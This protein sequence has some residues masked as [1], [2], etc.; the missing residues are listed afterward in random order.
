MRSPGSASHDRLPLRAL[1]ALAT[2]AFITVLT[3][4]LPAGVLPGMSRDIGVSESAMGQS[5]TVYAIGSALAAVPLSAATAGWSRKRL[6]LSTV[7]GFAVANSVTAFATDYWLSMGARFVAGL[8]AGLVW[9]MLAGYARRVAPARQHGKAVAIVMAGVPLALS[10]GVPAGTFLGDAVGWRVTFWSMTGIAVVLMG[11]MLVLVPDFPG[12]VGRRGRVLGALAVPGVTAVL[13]A[14]A[15]YVLAQA[16]LYTYI[17]TYLDRAG[18]ADVIDVVLLVYGA[19]S[20]VAIWVVGTQIDRRLRGLSVLTM[21]LFS[22]AA[23]IM[24]ALSGSQVWVFAAVVLW[25]FSAGSMP[26]LLQTAVANAGGESADMA[27]AMLVTLWNVATAVGGVVGGLVLDGVG[28]GAFPW[29]CL[30]VAVPV[31]LLVIGARRHGFPSR[32]VEHAGELQPAER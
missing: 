24:G 26:T 23:G 3:E 8:A 31:L 25:G 16:I 32:S 17:S 19:A 6:L 10:F 29:L 22:V 30:G 14:T 4:A 9:A 5:V 18:L 13:V 2:A 1:S 7:A 28:A 21:V 20:V 11:A 12:E 27:Q 15:A